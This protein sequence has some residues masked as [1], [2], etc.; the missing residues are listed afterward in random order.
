MSD[1]LFKP[2]SKVE[3]EE[4]VWLWEP[5]IGLGMLTILE[6]DPNI[7]KSY[8]SMHLAAMITSG[9]VLPD[10]IHL[11]KG[12]VLYMT[13]ED[14]PA[15]TL[16]PRIE[17]MGGNANRI[18]FLDGLLTFSDEGLDLLEKEMKARPPRLI[19][20]DTLFS[21]IPDGMDA[22]KPN[23]IRGRL[24][25]LGRLAAEQKSAI[26][27]IR[28]WTKGDRGKAIYR[29]GGVIDI[30]GVARSSITIAVH[31]EDPNLR[32]MAHVKHNLSER[33]I[34]RLF[35]LVPKSNQTR[36]ILEW[37]GTSTL[38]AD[39]LQAGPRKD[40]SALDAACDF[41]RNQLKERPREASAVR[42]AAEARSFSARTIDRAKKDVGVIAKKG[43]KGWIWSLPPGT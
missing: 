1:E 24:H 20:V 30:I 11:G 18:R 33:G 29:G 37:R 42:K 10:G 32:A 17:A 39:D 8:L 28:H 2:L 12:R 9:G 14:D 40:A 35:A 26:L 38:T 3:P 23:A 31:P 13:T 15:Y 4:I 27:L 5:Y 36:P 22:S 16:R 19:V 41:L 25:A 7:G 6:G 21:F 43:V 34:S